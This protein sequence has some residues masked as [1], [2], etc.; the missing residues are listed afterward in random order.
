MEFSVIHIEV[1][2][3]LHFQRLFSPSVVGRLETELKGHVFIY[4]L[5]FNGGTG[6]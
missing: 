1:S 5:F 6:D 2:L 3:T 4:L